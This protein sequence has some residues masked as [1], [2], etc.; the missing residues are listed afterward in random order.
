MCP[1]GGSVPV[2]DEFHLVMLKI[3]NNPARIT[4]NWTPQPEDAVVVVRQLLEYILS[5][6]HNTMLPS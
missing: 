1:V 5:C 4:C 3:T 2:C 6:L